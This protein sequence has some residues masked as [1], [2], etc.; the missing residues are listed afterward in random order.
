M[1]RIVE[2]RAE[3]IVRWPRTGRVS[4]IRT[5]LPLGGLS[6]FL[7]AQRTRQDERVE[8]VR[9][10]GLG[11]RVIPV[12]LTLLPPD[13]EALKVYDTRGKTEEAAA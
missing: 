6:I 8:L 7:A 3:F 9:K 13:G 4:H 2:Y 1:S 5:D 12:A 10:L 11:Q